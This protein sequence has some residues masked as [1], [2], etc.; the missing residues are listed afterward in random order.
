[1]KLRKSEVDRA[2]NG[3]TVVVRPQK[4]KGVMV[5]TIRLAS[6]SRATVNQ[7]I[8]TNI[9]KNGQIGSEIKSQLRMIN[10]CGVNCPMAADSRHRKHK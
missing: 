8:F 9:V 4:N 10:K 7:V 6:K 3:I 5:S 1:M 2:S